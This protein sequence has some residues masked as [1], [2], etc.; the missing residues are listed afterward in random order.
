MFMLVAHSGCEK[1]PSAFDL[2]SLISVDWGSMLSH[3]LGVAY[4]THGSVTSI[5]PEVKES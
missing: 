3:D 2:G 5:C 1:N 4:S